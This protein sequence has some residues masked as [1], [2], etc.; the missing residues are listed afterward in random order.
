MLHPVNQ[1]TH[2]RQP[3]G[4]GVN[5]TETGSTNMTK[6]IWVNVGWSVILAAGLAAPVSAH[7]SFS[8][9][10]MSKTV[11]ASA[12]LKEFRWGAPHSAV[13]FVIKGPDG[14]PQEVP[15]ASAS[16]GAFA[17]QG[18]KPR[19]FK[20][21]DKM[22]ITW[23]PSKSGALGGSLATMKLPDGRKFGETEFGAGGRA[24]GGPGDS[25]AND[26]QLPPGTERAK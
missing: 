1:R 14:K 7:H 19:D 18:F 10:D 16:P 3:A 22:E 25:Q 26:A 11:S 15:M 17:K 5:S 13:V 2:A 6:R 9:Y 24:G 23:H 4:R 8:G 21:G 20:V 12:T